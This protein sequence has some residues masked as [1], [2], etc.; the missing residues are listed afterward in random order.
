MLQM[1]EDQINVKKKKK[2]NGANKEDMC[3]YYVNVLLSTTY[4]LT[5][6]NN[7]K[8]RKNVGKDVFNL[9]RLIAQPTHP[10]M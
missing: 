7:K 5:L 4:G 8:V 9:D 2:Q 6:I 10:R 1:D 3:C